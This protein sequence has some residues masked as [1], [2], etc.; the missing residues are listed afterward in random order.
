[1]AI[2]IAFFLSEY[3]LAITVFILGCLTTS[4]LIQGCRE[5]AIRY[6][7]LPVNENLLGKFLYSE[8]RKINYEI[9]LMLVEPQ[10][11]HFPD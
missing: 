11:S 4:N 7:S 6:F 1:V 2:D 10:N 8:N 9:K 5:K 3:D